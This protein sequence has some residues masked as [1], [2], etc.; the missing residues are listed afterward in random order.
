MRTHPTATRRQAVAL[1]AGLSATLA[2]T[3][4]SGATAQGYPDRPVRMVVAFPAGGSVDLVARIVSAELAHSLNQAVVVENRTGASGNVGAEHV[5][6]AAPDGHTLF[7]GSASSLAANTALF[8][9]LPYDPVRDFAPISLVA[10]QPNVVVVHPSVPATTLA[11]LVAHARAN[12]GRLNY[13]TAGAGSTQHMATETFRRAA[14]IEMVHVPYRGG[15]PALS[16]LIA[17]QV[18]VMFET[19]PTAIEPVRAG[20]LRALAVTTRQRLTRLPE[21]PTVAES[22]LPGYE[23]RGWVGLVAPA[24]TKPAIIAEL[25]RRVAGIIRTPQVTTRLL[26][27]GLEVVA[28][29]PAEFASFIRA[30]VANYRAVVAAVGVSLD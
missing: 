1:L 27:L 16:D 12:P 19:V 21:L 15:A 20:Q 3:L 10:L 9:N 13:G 14:D 30:E 17:G 24:G 26:D 6:R 18:Q 22:G 23:S 25:H 8:R 11:E 29:T 7:M 28:G 5:A 4:P 2:T